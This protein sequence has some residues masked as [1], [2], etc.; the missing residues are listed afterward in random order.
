MSESGDNNPFSSFPQF[1]PNAG[2]QM[3]DSLLKLMRMPDSFAD[4]GGSTSSPLGPRPDIVAQLM[5]VEELD[6]RIIDLQAVEQW[7]KLNLSML[8]SMIQAL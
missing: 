1:S 7:L 6:K 5:S 2:Y 8:Q 3:F 4:G